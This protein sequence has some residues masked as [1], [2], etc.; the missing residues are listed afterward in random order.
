MNKYI[1]VLITASSQEEAEK[2]ANGLVDAE[3]AACVNIVPKIK[4]IFKWQGKKDAADE[5]LLIAKTKQDRFKDLKEAVKSLHSYDVPE[6][7][8]IPISEGNE[9]YLNWIAEVVK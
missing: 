1:V 8:S 6:I 2:I 9:D 7:I 5:V 3:V 4:S